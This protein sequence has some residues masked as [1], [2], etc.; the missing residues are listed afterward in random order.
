MRDSQ[1]QKLYKAE[2]NFLRH[3]AADEYLGDI[4]QCQLFVNQVMRRAYVKKHYARGLGWPIRVKGVPNKRRW[5]H[6]YCGASLIELGTGT[7][8]EW[9]RTRAVVLHEMAHILAYRK[10]MDHTGSHNWQFA[11]VF[12]DLVRNVMGVEAAKLLKRGYKCYGVRVSAPR[13]RVM[14]VEQKDAAAARLEV[15]RTKR[16]KALEPKRAMKERAIKLH[17]KRR[18]GIN[19]FGNVCYEH[20][21]GSGDQK[22]HLNKAPQYMTYD[23]I[24]CA[25]RG[26]DNMFKMYEPRPRVVGDDYWSEVARTE[27]RMVLSKPI[28]HAIITGIIS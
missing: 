3:C 6:A 7:S 26:Y 11:L 10:Y 4:D 8:A 24:E 15:A 9:S 2:Q 16:E 25:L 12:H 1:K 14:T 17:G 19:N 21:L 20:Y 23:Q 13:K 27:M 22:F 18:L 5:A 28:S